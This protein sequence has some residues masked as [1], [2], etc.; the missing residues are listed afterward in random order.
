MCSHQWRHYLVQY[1]WHETYAIFDSHINYM[2]SRT[3]A[4]SPTPIYIEGILCDLQFYV[5]IFG[6]LQC[7]KVN[8]TSKLNNRQSERLVIGWPLSW[9]PDFLSSYR[10]AAVLLVNKIKLC[11]P[12]WM[13][14]ALGV[15]PCAKQPSA[16]RSECRTSQAVK[17]ARSTF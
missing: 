2:H 5:R 6:K 17:H 10:P 7:S 4:H 15:A 1:V 11:T 9:A 8:F 14:L 3:D 16:S 13:P 12:N